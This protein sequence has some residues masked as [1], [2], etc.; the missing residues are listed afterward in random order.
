MISQTSGHG[1]FRLLSTLP[2]ADGDLDYTRDDRPRGHRRRRG[3]GSA[4]HPRTADEGREPD[5]DHGR[6]R[7]VTSI[8]TI[9]STPRSIS[10]RRCA[11]RCAPPPT[12]GT[13]V[14][15]HV[16]TPEGIQRSL[17]R[18]REV[19]FEQWPVGRPRIRADECATKGHGGRSSRSCR[20]KD[21]NPRSNPIQQQKA[22]EVARGTVQAF[23]M[24]RSEGVNM[25]FGTDILLNPGASRS[26]GRQTG[27]ADPVHVPARDA[28]DGHGQCR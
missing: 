6:R 21:S 23:E 17:R 4:P 18:R 2:R 13:Y 22:E 1:D 7:G 15:A 26:Q 25:A 12:G 16:Y 11:R 28:A 5:Q 20:T 9:R 3:R 10:K 14:C 24:G 8:L 27:Q 19:R